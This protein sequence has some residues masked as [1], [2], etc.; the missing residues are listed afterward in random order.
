MG[1]KQHTPHFI[2]LSV[3]NTEEVS[4]LGLTVSRKVGNAVQRNRVKRLVR[5]FFRTTN[6]RYDRPFDLSV[7]A[8][9]GAATL[10]IQQISAELT[11]ALN[12]GGLT[13]G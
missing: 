2:L 1:C 3:K 6:H 8:K 5:E 9:K 11:V 12:Q 13:N 10:S 4:R 7:V